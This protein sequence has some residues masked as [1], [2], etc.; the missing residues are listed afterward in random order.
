MN[1]YEVEIKV[2][3]TSKENRD[4]FKEK[5]SH[6]LMWLKFLWKNSQLNH[7]FMWWNFDKL[8]ENV[9]WLLPEDKQESFEN[10]L[11]VSWK[12]SFR[13]RYLNWDSILVIKLAIN[14]TASSSNW[15]S[16]LEWEHVF[17]KT[18]IDELDKKL[19]D[20]DFEYQAKW[21]REREEYSSKNNITIT[22]D[23]NAWYGYLS[24]FEMVV[25]SKEDA[26]KAEE[27]I[28]KLLWELEVEELPQD[29]LARM[30]AHYNKNWKDYYGTDKFFI[31][32]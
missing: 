5:L 27:S 24:E 19:L 1:N 10:I 16:R 13:T 22:I 2:L 23:K 32:D 17:K 21:S 7:Y 8:K 30:F 3:L 28:R 29:R 9:F 18:E 25:N 11:K 4:K 15:V 6:K 31:I 20:S 26:K 14:N 12:H